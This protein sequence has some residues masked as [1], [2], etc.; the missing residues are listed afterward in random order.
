[1]FL[2]CEVVNYNSAKAVWMDGSPFAAT[3]ATSTIVLFIFR[4]FRCGVVLWHNKK[5]MLVMFFVVYVSNH[6]NKRYEFQT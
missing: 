6:K 5:K 1:M 3:A 4:I 2:C